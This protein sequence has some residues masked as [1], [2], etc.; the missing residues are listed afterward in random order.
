MGKL[1]FLNDEIEFIQSNKAY[2]YDEFGH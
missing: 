1:I 2:R